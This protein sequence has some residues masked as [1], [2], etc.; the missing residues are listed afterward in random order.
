MTLSELLKIAKPLGMT[1]GNFYK[2]LDGRKTQTRRVI[3]PAPNN[4]EV[5]G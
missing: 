1:E 4:M 2:C 3:T 5:K